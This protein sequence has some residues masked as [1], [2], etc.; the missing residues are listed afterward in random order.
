MPSI[1]VSAVDVT[2]P[3]AA[4]GSVTATV[5]DG[6]VGPVALTMATSTLSLSYRL[7]Q[8]AGAD[9]AP[10]P[11]IISSGASQIILLEAGEVLAGAHGYE[12]AHDGV[13]AQTA[14]LEYRT[15]A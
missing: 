11:T 8:I 6:A 2:V 3:A 10:L 5:P 1:Q 15:R 7:R 4:A 9:L 13:G 14:V 12:L